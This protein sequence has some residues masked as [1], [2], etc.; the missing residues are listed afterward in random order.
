MRTT[1][2]HSLLLNAREERRLRPFRH[3][4]FEIGKTFIGNGEGIQPLNQ[5]RMRCLITACAMKTGG[6]R[7]D[8]RAG[9]STI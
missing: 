6:I 1:M 7:G 8:M 5:N 4:I 2:T 9:F 3:Q